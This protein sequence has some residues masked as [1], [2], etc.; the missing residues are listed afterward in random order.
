M[1]QRIRDQFRL[2]IDAYRTVFEGSVD[3]VTNTAWES[4]EAICSLKSYV[5]AIVH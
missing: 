1:L 2:T 4:D 3:R 5:T